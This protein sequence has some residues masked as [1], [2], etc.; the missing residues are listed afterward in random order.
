MSEAAGANPDIEAPDR[1]TT[2]E[3]LDALLPLGFAVLLL[4]VAGAAVIAVAA[5]WARDLADVNEWPIWLLAGG[6]YAERS[7]VAG[8]TVALVLTA[9]LRL[10]QTILAVA[11]IRRPKVRERL[12]L[13]FGWSRRALAVAGL[14]LLGIAAG[15]ALLSWCGRW[16]PE[17]ELAEDA[18]LGGGADARLRVTALYVALLFAQGLAGPLAEEVICRGL[19]YVPLR[20]SHGIA[21][22]A[23]G[24]AAV[25]ALLHRPGDL[26]GFGIVFLGGVLFALAC[27]FGRGLAA[28]LLV[29]SIYN[30]ALVVLRKYAE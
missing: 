13:R 6:P 26:L 24:S 15:G 5:G 8:E 19:L 3:V 17:A 27:E 16:L 23:A 14:M 2:R 28:P 1:G 22:S 20:R 10:I 29:H 18:L 9:C 4:E 11:W 21:V 7:E 30:S 12:R 25:F